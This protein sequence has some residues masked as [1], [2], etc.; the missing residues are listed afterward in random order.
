MVGFLQAFSTLQKRKDSV[1]CVGLDPA[2]PRQRAKD[3]I[4]SKY[5][6]TADEN[7]ARLSFCLD[8]VEQAKEYSIAA[9]PNQQYVLGFTKQQHRTLTDTIRKSRMLSILDYKLNDIR[10]TVESSLFHLAECGYDAITFN[11][12]LGNLEEVI[13]LAHESVKKTRGYELGIIVLTLTS[14]PEAVRYLKQATLDEQPLYVSIARDIRRHEADGAVIGATGHITEDDVRLVRKTI[15]EEKILLFPGIGAQKGDPEKIIKT[16][17]RNI[18]IN[19]SRDIIYS[20]N[21]GEKA[22]AYQKLFNEIREAHELK[23]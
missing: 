6:A 20:D 23:R 21:P 8:V 1:L 3:V 19:V 10:D 13:K 7:E 9:K 17:G 2:L 4:S 5:L 11:P 18:L 15:G 12:L 14:N 22:E 16:G